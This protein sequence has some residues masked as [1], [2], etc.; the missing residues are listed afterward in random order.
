MFAASPLRLNNF[1]SI[2]IC[3]S[4]A[5]VS[6]SYFLGEGGARDLGSVSGE[7]CAA[8]LIVS[9]TFLFIFFPLAALLPGASRVTFQSKDSL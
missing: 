3:I 7:P 2:N 9:V 4:A 5:A 1:F 8:V 6:Y